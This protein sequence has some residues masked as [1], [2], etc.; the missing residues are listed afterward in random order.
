MRSNPSLYLFFV[1]GYKVVKLGGR[2]RV[3]W[4]V[5]VNTVLSESDRSNDFYEAYS[6]IRSHF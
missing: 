4:W 2:F 3:K 1:G 6:A 5:T